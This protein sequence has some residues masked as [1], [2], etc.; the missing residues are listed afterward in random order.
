MQ[1]GMQ[2][3]NVLSRHLTMMALL[4]LLVEG[5]G[6]SM[7]M[8]QRAVVPMISRCGCCCTMLTPGHLQKA[9]I[10]VGCIPYE[11]A[12]DDLQNSC[13]SMHRR[14]GGKV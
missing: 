11:A 14:R 6:Q 8:R 1:T 2:Y 10:T 3:Y 5:P 4:L 13:R 7:R 9:L 12:A